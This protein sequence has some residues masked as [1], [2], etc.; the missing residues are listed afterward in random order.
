MA[1]YVCNSLGY[2][3]Y[4]PNFLSTIEFRENAARILNFFFFSTG[5]GRMISIR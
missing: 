3:T 1:F 2:H 4:K 5:M